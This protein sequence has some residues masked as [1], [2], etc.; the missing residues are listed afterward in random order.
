[1]MRTNMIMERPRLG[2]AS[3]AETKTKT[4][5]TTVLTTV[6]S[7]TSPGLASEG[8][9]PPC[10]ASEGV[11]PSTHFQEKTQSRQHSHVAKEKD[12]SWRL[13]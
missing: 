4:R 8:V 1:M 10:L 7:K 5:I 11:R 13:K 12:A 2:E 6:I 9:E 3:A